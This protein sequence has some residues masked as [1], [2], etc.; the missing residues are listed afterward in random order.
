M[1]PGSISPGVPA[2][3]HGVELLNLLWVQ[4]LPRF[5]ASLFA[6]GLKLWLNL[7][8]QLGFLLLHVIDN[9]LKLLRLRLRERQLLLEIVDHPVPAEFPVPT[10]RVPSVAVHA[11]SANPQAQEKDYGE[12]DVETPLHLEPLACGL[13]LSV[14]AEDASDY[15]S[16]AYS[17]AASAD[18]TESAPAKKDEKSASKKE[19][20]KA[21]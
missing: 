16:A 18:R 11:G 12:I 15:R 14:G 5:G 19:T 13:V 21:Q 4:N 9:L 3:N 1:V 2:F 17:K 8:A 7:V 6:N 10:S 20:K